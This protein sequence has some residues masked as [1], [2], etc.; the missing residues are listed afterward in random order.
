MVA[1]AADDLIGLGMPSEQTS[2]LDRLLSGSVQSN[3]SAI[4][5]T[6][7][8]STTQLIGD[9]C[10]IGSCSRGSNDS[11]QLRTFS[12]G[13]RR[14]QI[15][16]NRSGSLC[17]V[18]PPTGGFIGLSGTGAAYSTTA[19]FSLANNQQV[20]FQAVAAKEYWPGRYSL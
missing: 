15:V 8:A 13:K 18:W 5:T 17:Q 7:S 19:A 10:L 11:V 9:I 16:I 1:T 20:E 3:I 14:T 12:Y 2:A 6:L 4:G